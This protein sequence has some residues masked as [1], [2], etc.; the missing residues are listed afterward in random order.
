MNHLILIRCFD[1]EPFHELVWNDIEDVIN[2]KRRVEKAHRREELP[3]KS[4][5]ADCDADDSSIVKKC[6]HTECWNQLV[7]N[8]VHNVFDK[9]VALDNIR[10]SSFIEH[11]IDREG[12]H[13]GRCGNNEGIHII[14]Y[15]KSRSFFYVNSQCSW[16]SKK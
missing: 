13:A 4:L 14:Y 10:A 12:L 11:G 5:A 3:A 2:G 15:C 1:T 8:Y 16:K 6:E 9:F 7:H